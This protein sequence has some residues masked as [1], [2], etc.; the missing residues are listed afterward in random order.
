M[1][2]LNTQYE[3]AMKHLL[4]YLQGSLKLKLC[5]RLTKSGKQEY[6]QIY[7]DSDYTADKEDR[8][9]ISGGVAILG[10]GAVLWVSH[11]QSTVITSSTKAEYIA[12]FR[13]I[14]TV[15]WDR[16]HLI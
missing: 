1:S 7:S 12:L 16:Q 9:S 8:R 4:R 11:K 14:K 13:N 15:L 3:L 6:V 10:G 5:Y 2:N